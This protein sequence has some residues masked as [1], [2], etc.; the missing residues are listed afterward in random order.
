MI[1]HLRHARGL[2]QST[3][4]RGERL[5]DGRSA[6]GRCG[7]VGRGGAGL[8]RQPD[9]GGQHPERQQRRQEPAEE[10]R[11]GGWMGQVVDWT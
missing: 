7:A 1:L 11:E 6:G 10:H 4:Y 5:D 8:A 9:G 3:P 2:L